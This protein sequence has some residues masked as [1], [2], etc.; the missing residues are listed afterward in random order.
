M[1]HAIRPCAE[2]RKWYCF[3]TDTW[4][5]LTPNDKFTDATGLAEVAGLGCTRLG[6]GFGETA[7]ICMQ[8]A[9][10]IFNVL[11]DADRLDVAPTFF[12][13]VEERLV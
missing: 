7:H 12:G 11:V 1:S 6:G 8:P 13:L 3:L 2:L 5:I 10:T 9:G 4:T